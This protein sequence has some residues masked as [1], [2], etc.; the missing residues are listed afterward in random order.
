MK[1]LDVLFA[2]N[3]RLKIQDAMDCIGVNRTDMA[4]AAM[5]LGLNQIIELAARKKD[6]A[7]ELVVMTAYKAKQ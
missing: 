3:Q 1:K 7:Q 4:R 5:E 6:A 2:D